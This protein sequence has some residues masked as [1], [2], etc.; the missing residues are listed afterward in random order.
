MRS[1]KM[2]EKE[3]LIRE[4]KKVIITGKTYT[5]YIEALADHL[6]TNYDITRK[7]KYGGK[8]EHRAGNNT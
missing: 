2:S 4:L 5:E 7:N 6:L 1:K 3:S 8:I